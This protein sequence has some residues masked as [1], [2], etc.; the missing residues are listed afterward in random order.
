[1]SPIITLDYLSI[2]ILLAHVRYV[3]ILRD[4]IRE[5][6]LYPGFSVDDQI[7]DHFAPFQRFDSNV[8]VNECLA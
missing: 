8:A 1:M 5:N 3:D 2:Q 7:P 4:T 6:M